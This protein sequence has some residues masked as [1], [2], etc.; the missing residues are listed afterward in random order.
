VDES[1]ITGES[2][3]LDKSAGEK[4]FAGSI[5]QSSTLEIAAQKVGDDT[6]LARILRLV[7]EAQASQAPIQ[8]IADKAA[9]WYLPAALATAAIVWVGMCQPRVSVPMGMRFA[10]RV[11]VL[12]VL[13]VV[14]EM[15]V[16][17][18]LMDVLVF[19]SLVTCSQTPIRPQRRTPNRG[20][21]A[22]SR[23]RAR[24]LQTGR[25]RMSL[26]EPCQDDGAPERKERVRRN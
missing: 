9:Q 22:R 17:Q 21:L 2:A 13:V 23:K 16:F 20:G 14:V 26:C 5:N 10:W 1:P 24:C 3:P 4:V 7:E 18:R 6:T 15:F 12:V 25:W 11:L 19:V 8:R